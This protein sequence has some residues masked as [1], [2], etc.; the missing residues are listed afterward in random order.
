MEGTH[1]HPP[2]GEGLERRHRDCTA[3]MHHTPEFGSPR[4]DHGSDLTDGAIADR[5]HE[6]VGRR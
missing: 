1:R 4:G 5:D 2:R 6:Q 3:E